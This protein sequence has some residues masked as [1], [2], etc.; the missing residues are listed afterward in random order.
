MDVDS[1]ALMRL[2]DINS[3]QFSTYGL[4]QVKLHEKG[5]DWPVVYL[6]HNASE[7]YVG[8]TTSACNRFSQHLANPDRNRLEL[9]E[10]VFDDAFNK[11][12]VLDI[13]QTL[14]KLF[15][16]DNSMT[17]QNRNGGQ[18]STHNYYQR[19]AYQHKADLIWNELLKK[20]LADKPASVIRNSNLF[21]YSPYTVLTQEQEAASIEILTHMIECLE[22]G[23]KGTAVISGTAGTGKSVVVINMISCLSLSMSTLYDTQDMTPEER[24]DLEPRISLANKIQKYVERHGHLRIG[25]VVPMTSIRKTFKSVFADSRGA[26]LRGSM[27]IGPQ[28]VL[29]EQYDIVFVDESHRL[30]QRKSLTSYGSFDKACSILGLDRKKATQLDMVQLRSKYSILVYDKNQTVK[31]SDITD[32]QFERSLLGRKIIRRELKSQMRC[33]GGGSFTEYIDSILSNSLHSKKDILDYDFKIWDNPNAMIKRIK[34]LDAEMSLCRVVAGYGW[35]WNTK[36]VTSAEEAL[37]KGLYDIEL[38][39]EKY[40]WNMSNS[41]W[42]LRPESINEIGCIHTTQGYDL[43]YVAVV[44][45]PEIDYDPV[46][47]SIVIDRNKFYDSKV[48]SGVSDKDLKSFIINSYAV[49]MKR[50]IKGCYVYAFNPALRDYLKRFIPIQE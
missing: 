23:E 21:K 10:I 45:G 11:S 48:K 4:E 44:F 49:M 29:K 6:I 27:V 20:N 40:V 16:A 24:S 2:P 36:G 32:A 14:I 8:E 37:S 5:R 9:I 19:S 17:L 43:N 3:Y 42:I 12:A 22:R 38:D 46:S 50:G 13:E 25:F 34:E 47:D 26:G 1:S 35:K 28:D 33:L 31:S 41:E 7:L 15:A 18:S 39:G 30:A